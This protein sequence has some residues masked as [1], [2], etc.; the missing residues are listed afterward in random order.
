MSSLRDCSSLNTTCAYHS[1]FNHYPGEDKSDILVFSII[2]KPA[3]SIISLDL[4]M[5]QS[6][7]EYT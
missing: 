5:H 3:C 6:N 4:N 1:E 2:R 7:L